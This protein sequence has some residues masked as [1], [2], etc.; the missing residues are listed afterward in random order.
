MESE[1]IILS[2]LT[3]T[4]GPN[5]AEA[6]T[7]HLIEATSAKSAVGAPLDRGSLL[8]LIQQ[9]VEYYFSDDNLPKDVFLLKQIEKDK[10]KEGFVSLKVLSERQL[11]YLRSCCSVLTAFPLNV[12]S[13]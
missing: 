7:N 10:T 11:N 9:Q 6:S 13:L 2:P 1:T 8:A 12:K 4:L 5:F 3:P